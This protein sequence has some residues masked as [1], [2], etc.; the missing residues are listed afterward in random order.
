MPSLNVVSMNTTDYKTVIDKICSAKMV[1]SS[2][3]HGIILAEAYGV[4]AV[5]YQ[6][7]PERFNYKYADWYGSTGREDFFVAQSIQEAMSQ[8][9]LKVPDLKT[10][11]ENL[12]HTFPYDLWE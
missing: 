7:R 5:F 8:T 11:Q 2:S 10:M 1:I 12:I 6:D 4:P 9:G 3:L